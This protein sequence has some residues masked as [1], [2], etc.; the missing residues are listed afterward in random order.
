MGMDGLGMLF[1]LQKEMKGV[2]HRLAKTTVE[3]SDPDGLVRAVVN[4]EYKL[5]EISLDNAL[6]PVGGER[7]EKAIISAVNTAVQKMKDL[8]A[9]E[10]ESLKN[11]IP[12][13]GGGAS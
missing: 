5:I 4:G 12:G 2:Q 1:K 13:M 11:S 3:G 6:L 8:S 7:A 9:R 10:V